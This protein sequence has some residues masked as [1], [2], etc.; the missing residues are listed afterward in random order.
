MKK[1]GL[2]L[3][4]ALFLLMALAPAVGLFV[5]GP[6]EAAANEILA[7]PPEAFD[8]EGN[9]KLSLLSDASDY[10]R[11]RF[12][13]RQELITANAALEA[14]VFDESASE[15]VILGK[16]GWLFF[17]DTLDDYQ[18][19]NRLTER[20]LWAAAHTLGLIR[21]YAEQR[22]ARTLFVPVPN[23]NTIYPEYMPGSTDRSAEPGNYDRLLAALAAEE[24]EALDLR[25][26]LLAHKEEVQL[27][28]TLDS[29]WNNLGAALAHDAILEALGRAGSSY[30]PA[31]FRF[32]RDHSPDLYKMLY[33]AGEELDL[34]AYPRE[35]QSF[36]YLR[37]IRSPEDQRISTASETGEGKLL[38]FRDSFGNTLHSF[39]A[40]SF[41]QALFSRAMPYDLRLLDSEQ[42][43]TLILEITERHL[44]WLAERP[45]IMLAPTRE[46][47]LS[48]AVAAEALTLQAEENNGLFCLKGEL[49]LQPDTDSP[50]YLEAEGTVYEASP[51]G[52]TERSFAAW[53]PE[54]LREAR[55]CFYAGGVLCAAP[56]ILTP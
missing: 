11:D 46:T 38:M 56:A 13:L 17:R 23:K 19:Q 12:W 54:E 36:S 55:V 29:H 14:A 2:F 10:L 35:K 45:P 3:F 49:P 8:Q 30:D 48:G 21:E 40:E 37:P 42:P 24:V 32:E 16:E 44:R 5:F 9:F 6:A 41:S 1:I 25:P 50:V 22:G 39:M 51:V 31:A 20:Q 15:D 34:Q 28:Q 52:E 47:D 27:Y 4:L 18:G 26:T 43:E 53:L 33:P 7:Q